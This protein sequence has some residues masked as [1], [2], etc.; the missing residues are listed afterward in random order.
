M[1]IHP[2]AH[3]VRAVAEHLDL[4]DAGNA[5]EIFDDVD[6]GV[7]AHRDVADRRTRRNHRDGDRDVAGALLHRNALL[8]HRRRQ[9]R[10]REIDAVLHVGLVGRRIGAERER[11][12]DREMPLELEYDC[13]YCSPSAPLM[14]ISSGV[15]TERTTAS[16]SAPGK[17]AVTV[18]VGGEICGYCEIGRIGMQIKPA[19]NTTKLKTPAKSGRLRKTSIKS[20]TPGSGALSAAFAKRGGR[21]LSRRAPQRPRIRVPGRQECVGSEAVQALAIRVHVIGIEEVEDRDVLGDDPPD[22]RVEPLAFRLLGRTQGQR[23]RARRPARRTT[24]C[25]WKARRTRAPTSRRD[26]RPSSTE[27]T[28][29]RRSRARARRST[30]ERVAR[31]RPL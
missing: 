17:F 29:G 15:V 26:R 2:D 4:A 28:R 21:G 11:A 7:V 24:A 22:A 20:Q 6:V 9:L 27:R 30:A 10:E 18:T 31:W 3:A 1:R 12:R 8:L 5:L 23:A 14:L 19:S 25:S 13:M 16:A